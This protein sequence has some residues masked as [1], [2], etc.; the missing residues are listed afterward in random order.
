M[1]LTT[2]ILMI[3]IVA[4]G[5]TAHLVKNE[6]LQ[7]LFNTTVITY[8][9]YNLTIVKRNFIFSDITFT[10]PRASLIGDILDVSRGQEFILLIILSIIFG[11]AIYFRRTI[12]TFVIKM[13][14]K[15]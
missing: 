5:I 3:A 6:R 15:V 14:N 9:A 7:I 11:L 8:I 10:Y 1:T 13:I 12:N 2:I 4:V